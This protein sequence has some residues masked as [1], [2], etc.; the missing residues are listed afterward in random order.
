MPRRRKRRRSWNRSGKLEREKPVDSHT[1]GQHHHHGT[2]S[3]L[4]WSL[5]ATT[6]FV[7]VELIAGLKAHSLALLSDAGHNFTDALAL[8][9][10]WAANY[11]QSMPA[12]ES[13]TF[14]Y[15]RAG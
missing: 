6:L 1:H 12:N 10:A 7:V 15:H 3:V 14:G 5:I 8:G 11:L 2:G 9:L 4:R 13:K